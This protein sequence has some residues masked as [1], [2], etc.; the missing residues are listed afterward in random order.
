VLAEGDGAFKLISRTT[1]VKPP[2]QVLDTSTNG[3]RDLAVTVSGG[4]ILKPYV[5]RIPFDGSSYATNPSMPPASPVEN[6][7][8]QIL[9]DG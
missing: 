8:G 5:A 6:V 7:K 9:I 3:W 1:I 2:I 4:G